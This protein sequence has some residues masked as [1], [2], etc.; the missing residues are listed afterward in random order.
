MHKVLTSSSS[1]LRIDTVPVPGTAGVIGMTICPGKKDLG[2]GG[3]WDRDLVAD[4]ET[5][6]GWGC[7][8]LV[9]L[10]EEHEFPLLQVPHLPGI[11]LGFGMAWHHLPIRDVS[12]PDDLFENLWEESGWRLRQILAEGGRVVLHCRGGI[13]RT[14][15]IAARLLVEFGVV[16]EEAIRMVRQARPGT[17]ETPAQEAYVLRLER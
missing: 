17:I 14:G 13:G 1:P 12:V 10:M 5:V 6:K 9:T 2:L 4:L 16:P 11:V 3:I 8:A 15:T 7:S